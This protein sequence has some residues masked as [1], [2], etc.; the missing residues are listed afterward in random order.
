MQVLT[1]V[2]KSVVTTRDTTR[3]Q[4]G[5]S[6]RRGLDKQIKRKE[7]KKKVDTDKRKGVRRVERRVGGGY[8]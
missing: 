3:T 2:L 6:V 5:R 7:K 8:D 4:A 1:V